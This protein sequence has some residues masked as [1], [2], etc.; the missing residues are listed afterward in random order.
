M[1]TPS[2]VAA[3]LGLDQMEVIRP[4]PFELAPFVPRAAPKGTRPRV[5]RI[6]EEVMNG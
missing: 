6:E 5:R 2:E 1:M 4:V 3:E